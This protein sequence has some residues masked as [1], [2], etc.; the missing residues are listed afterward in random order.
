V[1]ADSPGPKEPPLGPSNSGSGEW[2]PDGV[3]ECTCECPSCAGVGIWRI[4]G[5]PDGKGEPSLAIEASL[6]WEPR[7][8]DA[9]S[10]EDELPETGTGLDREALRG[11]DMVEV[12]SS[13]SGIWRL[14][15]YKAAGELSG[16]FMQWKT[17][18]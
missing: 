6:E 17:Q 5:V 4:V 1:R 8:G 18:E 12:Q 14:L 13:C 15:I 2:V 11:L 10:P 7:W 3:W 16:V 9:S